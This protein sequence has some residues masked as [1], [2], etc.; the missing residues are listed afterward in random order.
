[1][2][3]FRARATGQGC[4]QLSLEDLSAGGHHRSF[5]EP[6]PPRPPQLA[7]TKSNL[8]INLANS[9]CQFLVTS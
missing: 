9:V 6:S 4:R 1:M 7:D 2:T 3:S 5:A 8:C